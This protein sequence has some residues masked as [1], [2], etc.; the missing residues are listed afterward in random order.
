MNENRQGIPVVMMIVFFTLPV[1]LVDAQFIKEHFF[2]SFRGSICVFPEQNGNLSDPSLILPTLGAAAALSFKAFVLELSLDMYGADYGYSY[3]L[4]RPVP[5]EPANRSAFVTGSV[6]ALN[7]MGQFDLTRDFALRLYAGPAL[8]LRLCLLS[9]NLEN[10]EIDENNG[11][12]LT[13]IVEDISAY[14]WSEGRY[15]LPLSGLGFD[16]RILPA[17]MLGLDMRVWFPVYKLW[18]GED[19]PPLEGWRFGGGIKVSIR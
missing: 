18:T 14:F 2:Y 1:G 11:K 16:Y 7:V 13:S 15:F 10:D 12:K 3:E 4:G 19:L 5:A 9:Y 8:D 17:V 6:L